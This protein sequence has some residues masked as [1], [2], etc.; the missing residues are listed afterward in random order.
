MPIGL[1]RDCETYSAFC[2]GT[3]EYELASRGTDPVSS[4]VPKFMKRAVKALEIRGLSS[5]KP[6]PNG[7]NEDLILDSSLSMPYIS[8]VMRQTWLVL[9]M[10]EA[11]PFLKHIEKLKR[12]IGISPIY[13]SVFMVREID[14][15]KY[16][17]VAKKV[18]PMS[19]QDPEA[20]IPVYTDIQIEP[21]KELPEI[22]K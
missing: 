15:A 2:I 5:E 16:K 12:G 1:C 19:T 10:E 11:E 20:G 9:G 22:P 3:S 13:D 4:E 18:V 7:L 21:L 8:E 17:S 14:G 6:R